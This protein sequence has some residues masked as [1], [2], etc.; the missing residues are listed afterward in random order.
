MTV[1]CAREGKVPLRINIDESP[2][3]IV[4]DAVGNIAKDLGSGSAGPRRPATRSER[5]I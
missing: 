3:P 2:M 4:Y 5:R 1:E